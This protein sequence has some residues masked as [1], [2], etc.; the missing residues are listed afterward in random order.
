MDSAKGGGWGAAC[1]RAP[2]SPGAAGLL[3]WGG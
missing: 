3:A 2:D 1:A